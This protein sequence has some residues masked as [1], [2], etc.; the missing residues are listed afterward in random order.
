MEELNRAL[1]LLINAPENPNALI[2]H[3]HGD[4]GKAYIAY[5]MKL[6]ALHETL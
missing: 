5:R 4:V 3:Y 1:F 2:L 6:E